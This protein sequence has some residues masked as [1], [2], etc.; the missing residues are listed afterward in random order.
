MNSAARKD[1]Y[2]FSCYCKRAFRYHTE[3]GLFDCSFYEEDDDIELK[4]AHED[5]NLFK[6]TNKQAILMA[7]MLG[8]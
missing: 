3:N 7:Q 2:G 4:C 6:C 1:L 8:Q 5:D